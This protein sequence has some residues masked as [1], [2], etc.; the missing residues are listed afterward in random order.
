MSDATNKTLRD[1][2]TIAIIQVLIATDGGKGKDS[3]YAAR[4][5]GMANEVLRQ[6]AEGR[7]KHLAKFTNRKEGEVEDERQ[8]DM[9]G[10]RVYRGGNR[11]E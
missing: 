11:Y 5:L 10:P 9:R 8:P 6:R 2:Y 7:K 4:A 1:E 3:D